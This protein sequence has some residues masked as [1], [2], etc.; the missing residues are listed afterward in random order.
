MTI[1]A[2]EFNSI[3]SKFKINATCFEDYHDEYVSSYDLTF[4]VGS[5]IKNIDKVKDELALAL[6]SVGRPSIK[7]LHD[8][9]LVNV[10]FISKQLE[11]LS[12]KESNLFEPNML[13]I[14]R[15]YDKSLLKI[16]LREDPHILIAGITGSGKST[17]LHTCISNLLQDNVRLVLVDTKQIEFARYK[18]KNVFTCLNYDD[19]YK[20]ISV[21]EK[22]ML[23]RYDNFNPNRQKIVCIIDEFVDL[24]LQDKDDT[25]KTKVCSLTQ[26]GRAAGI[27]FIV[28]TQRPAASIISGAIKANFSAKIS[29][30]MASHFDSKVILDH[31]GAEN[32]IGKGDALISSSKLF[33]ERFQA[34][35]P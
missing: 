12:V 13:T 22:E 24:I 23:F 8:R 2:P 7:I 28:A 16:D 30:K 17:L 34:Y 20:A 4:N 11:S 32:L 14:G 10:S 15:F 6:K 26:K 31:S 27:H 5:K 21:L 3:L 29:F 25:L 1:S 19:A 33:L 35:L 9:G 18:G